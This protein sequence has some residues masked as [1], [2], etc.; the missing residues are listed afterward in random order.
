MHTP[1]PILK[2][3]QDIDAWEAKQK[4][5]KERAAK[6]KAD[7][8]EAASAAA[9]IGATTDAGLNYMSAD[10]TAWEEAH[11]KKSTPTADDDNVTAAATEQTGFM[12][13]DVQA[14][15]A[16]MSK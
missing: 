10:V 11:N 16:N 7:A 4:Q 6:V 8:A 12:D 2:P 15:E 1:L 9:S 3:S 5:E 14:W 13:S